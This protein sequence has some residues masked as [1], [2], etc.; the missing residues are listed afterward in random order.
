[1]SSNIE[2]KQARRGRKTVRRVLNFE[3]I[4]AT[5][6]RTENL[7]SSVRE[8]LHYPEKKGEKDGHQ[9]VLFECTFLRRQ[10]ST[11]AIGGECSGGDGG[12]AEESWG[13]RVPSRG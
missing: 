4:L 7:E 13:R 10:P 12:K 1:V 6:H 5:S 8:V 3:K 9:A 11:V 2:C